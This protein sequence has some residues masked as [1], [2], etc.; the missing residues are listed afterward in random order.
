MLRIPAH[1]RQ[2]L[3]S[4]VVHKTLAHIA[5]HQTTG[6]VTSILRA[7]IIIK[8]NLVQILLNVVPTLD[9]TKMAGTKIVIHLVLI[10]SV[11]I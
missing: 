7:G 11:G 5:L 3:R 6:H 1:Y 8:D 10:P 2:E 9:L 4:R